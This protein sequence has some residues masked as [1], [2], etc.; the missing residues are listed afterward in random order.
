MGEP[1]NASARRVLALMALHYSSAI[2][3]WRQRS[4]KERCQVL[5]MHRSILC[6]PGDEAEN[7]GFAAAGD[8]LK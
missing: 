2:A 8:K 7:D 6:H 3:P 4:P 5:N 1:T